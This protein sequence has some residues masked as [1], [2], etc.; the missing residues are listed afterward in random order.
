MADFPTIPLSVVFPLVL[1]AMVAVAMIVLFSVH[2]VDAPRLRA[3]RPASL[4]LRS[5]DGPSGLS[6][7]IMNWAR[8][9]HVKRIVNAYS[10]YAC[11][12]EIIIWNSNPKER[13]ALA[14]L[15]ECDKVYTVHLGGK[16]LG[17][18][19]RFAGASMTTARDGERVHESAG[20]AVLIQDDDLLWSEHGL[21]QLHAKQ[22]AEP[23][24][25]HG[26]WGR[27]PTSVEPYHVDEPSQR[28]T[29]AAIVLTKTLVCSKWHVANFWRISAQLED[30][31]R[32][33]KPRANGEDIAFSLACLAAQKGKLHRVWPGLRAH[34]RELSQDDES[35]NRRVANHLALRKTLVT[36]LCKSLGIILPGS[37]GVYDSD[38]YIKV[39]APREGMWD[40]TPPAS[41]G[42]AQ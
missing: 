13:E 15:D 33:V 37:Q 16:D 2:M 38:T 1:A 14:E 20:D 40:L 17:L 27:M 11:V 36:E 29:H 25:V 22:R 34:V 26:V 42:F 6:I 41:M 39:A 4:T 18:T 24:V 8:T 3:Q 31:F 30:F 12:R 19:A 28:T 21:V 35:I 23:D 9:E 10:G 7:V 32:S 5:D